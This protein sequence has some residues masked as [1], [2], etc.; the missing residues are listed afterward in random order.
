M[1]KDKKQSHPQIKKRLIGSLILF[2]FIFQIFLFVPRPAQALFGV[3]DITFSTT[4]GD[5]PGMIWRAIDKV[6]KSAGAVAWQNALRTFTQQIAYKT[7]VSIASGGKGQTPLFTTKEFTKHV[8]EAGDA[9]VGDALD[10]LSTEAWGFSLCDVDPKIKIDIEA[11]LALDLGLGEPRQAKCTGTTIW[12]SILESQPL[13][14]TGGLGVGISGQDPAQVSAA[15]IKAFPDI[16]KPEGNN[17][18]QY[19]KAFSQVS[20]EKGKAE[21][22]A[23]EES[24]EEFLPLKSLITG[25]IKTP[26]ATIKSTQEFSLQQAINPEGTF[27]GELAADFIGVFTNTLIKKYLETIFTKGLNPAAD[28]GSRGG[29]GDFVTGGGGSSGVAAAEAKFASFTQP[30]LGGGGSVDILN[31]LSSCPGKFNEVENCVIDSNFR[32]AVE[33]HLRVEE[34]IAKGYL[35]G[36][37]PFGFGQG[38]GQL[39]YQNGYPYRSLVILRRHRI[40]P[41]SWELAALYIRQFGAGNFSLNDLIAK[42]DVPD[43]PFYHLIDP[44]WVLKAP[45]NYCRRQGFGEGVVFDEYFDD[46]GQDASPKARQIQRKEICV[47][48]QSCIV[49]NADGSCQAYGYCTEEKPIW[50]F[51]GEDCPDYYASCKIYQSRTGNQSSYLEDTLD[52]NGCSA[53]NVGCQWYCKKFSDTNDQWQC[54]WD[55]I[56]YGFWPINNPWGTAGVNGAGHYY[57]WLAHL[58]ASAETC[59]PSVAGCHEYLRTTNGSNLINNANFDYYTGTPDGTPLVEDVITS[60]TEGG[61]ADPKVVTAETTPPYLGYHAI[62]L[63]TGDPNTNYLEHQFQFSNN[64]SLTDRSFT[65]S[66]YAKFNGA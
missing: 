19:L 24:K 56:D 28:T 20:L 2:V 36:G 8:K 17:L 12:H 16:Y 48:D 27:T 50:R 15:L 58:D 53:D 11:N 42:Y 35:D 30:N 41:V 59:D 18:G 63:A 43:S 13:A 44:D 4:I 52:F 39:D 31:K 10:T 62:V 60:W 25:D 46:D 49:E 40:V 22:K 38:G 21:E 32:T 29:V 6:I 34:A 23:K 3:G 66:I 51:S 37:K 54:Y 47:D 1:Q 45:D 57:D 64:H 26:A 65:F 61:N 55:S 5:I 9:A 7:A 14:I 33:Q